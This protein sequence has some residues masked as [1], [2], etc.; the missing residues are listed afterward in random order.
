MYPIEV[1]AFD[2][3]YGLGYNNYLK[4]NEYANELSLDEINKIL[5]K[6]FDLNNAVIL[7][8]APDEED[9]P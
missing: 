7:S 6:S 2:E 1:S 5:K 8:I 9:A 3:I 4:F